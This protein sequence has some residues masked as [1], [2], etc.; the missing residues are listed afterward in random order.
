[1]MNVIHV[2]SLSQEQ[3]YSLSASP[4]FEAEENRMARGSGKGHGRNKESRRLERGGARPLW[5]ESLWVSA[6][7]K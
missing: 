1:M 7:L 3:L 5:H 4:F 6:S 2:C